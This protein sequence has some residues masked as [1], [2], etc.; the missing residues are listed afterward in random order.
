MSDILHQPDQQQFICVV[1]GK[2]S[3]LSYRWL[4]ASTVDAHSTQVPSELRGQGIADRLARSFHDWC[5][6]QGL[7]IVA[8]CSYVDVWLRRHGGKS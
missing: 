7:T 3:R 1:D 4:D 5:Q 6:A 2:T 8:S